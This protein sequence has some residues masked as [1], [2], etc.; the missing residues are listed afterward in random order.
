M[1]RGTMNRTGQIEL[2][3]VRVHNLKGVTVAFPLNRWTTVTG[4]SGSGKSSLVID[5]LFTEARRRYGQSLG[6]RAAELLRG[7]QKPDADAIGP[8]PPA[9][10]LNQVSPPLPY[11]VTVAALVE[12]IDPLCALFAHQGRFHCPECGRSLRPYTSDDVVD[13]LSGL[14]PGLRVVIAFPVWP[15]RC[16]L[17][18]GDEAGARRRT[19]GGE[20]A[21]DEPPGSW[22]EALSRA[23]AA[24]F[25]RWFAVTAGPRPGAVG[26]AAE[27]ARGVYLDGPRVL[28]EWA[29]AAGVA[30]AEWLAVVDRF[31]TPVRERRLR[32]AEAVETAYRYGGGRCAV[33]VRLADGAQA[34]PLHGSADTVFDQVLGVDGDRWGLWYAA[35]GLHCPRCR[36]DFQKPA[37]EDLRPC[38][39]RGLRAGAGDAA[40]PET[41]RS[42]G[43][44]PSCGG[45]GI[46][47]GRVDRE[48]LSALGESAHCS[49]C[50]GSGSN[51]VALGVRLGNGHGEDT[52]ASRSIAEVLCLTVTEAEAW[53]ETLRDESD[54]VGGVVRRAALN[55]VRARLRLLSDLG[56]G[57]LPLRRPVCSLGMSERRRAELVALLANG[58]VQAL[59]VLDEPTYGIHPRERGVVVRA[60]RALT[61]RPATVVVVD[62]AWEC[63][64]AADRVIELGPGAGREGGRVVSVE[65]RLPGGR[66]ESD[67]VD[68]TIADDPRSRPSG[69]AAG[70]ATDRPSA[71]S[72][73]GRSGDSEGRVPVV[74]PSPPRLRICEASARNL[75]GC[76]VCVPLLGLS[77]VTG[78]G[79]AGKTALLCDTIAAALTHGADDGAERRCRVPTTGEERV[80][81]AGGRVVLEVPEPHGRSFEGVVMI[82]SQRPKG[83]VRSCVASYLKFYDHIRRLMAETA[84]AVELGLSARSFSFNAP[85]GR[86]ERCHGLGTVTV[87]MRFLGELA[88]TCPECNGRRFAEEILQ[89]HYRGRSIAEILQLT[90]ADAF[91]FFRGQRRIQQPLQVVR[92][93]GLGYLTL[94][95]SLATLSGGEIQRI[96]LAR[97]LLAAARGRRLILVD[98]PSGG[99]HDDDVRRVLD[100]LRTMTSVGHAVIVADHHPLVLDAAD[101]IVE[102]GPGGGSDGGTV[103]YCGPKSDWI[104]VTE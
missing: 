17:S 72:T 62:H 2:R 8:L 87:D 85:A 43:P 3:G 6:A 22:S 50:L 68:S 36:V 83:A 45:T 49:R 91:T 33:L 102:L 31:K 42:A 7:L 61:G 56:L 41:V 10:V 20:A 15:W 78:S 101:W 29:D 44:C 86:C 12:L 30:V 69:S 94:G 14:P 58:L 97:E 74:E 80:A 32:L 75:R 9:V 18:S 70:G 67:R 48:R 21:T 35:L 99:L 54:R 77:V 64:E 52:P 53:L 40:L 55:A 65:D 39:Y 71:R 89:V 63:I 100:C 104:P 1:D 19:A 51:D 66:D 27:C 47:G 76:S 90:V 16:G 24:G 57:Y 28:R 26:A 60:L 84:D 96:K 37:A 4:V 46:A 79:G 93:V 95:Q 81:P 11:W 98:L 38:R 88:V 34:A 73:V 92:D 5:T 82:E 13:W 103:V 59:Y 25:R 23:A